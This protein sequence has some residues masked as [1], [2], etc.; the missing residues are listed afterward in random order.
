[1]SGPPP[2]HNLP[3]GSL[4]S[5]EEHGQMATAGA[6]SFTDPL[7]LVGRDSELERVNTRVRSTLSGNLNVVAI[8]GEPGIGKT[9]FARRIAEQLQAGQFVVVWARSLE[10]DWQPQYQ[11]W[12][13]ILS[14]AFAAISW[15]PSSEGDP[16]WV[17]PLLPIVARLGI[18]YP[19]VRPLG[20]LSTQE[21]Q[22]RVTDAI[23]RCL[24]EL[25]RHQPLLIVIDDLQWT[26]PASLRVL[27]HL[28]A[29]PESAS[30][31]VVATIRNDYIDRFP[32]LADL[33]NGLR[34]EDAFEEIGLQGLPEAQVGHLMWIVGHEEFPSDVVRLIAEGTQGNP[35]F[36]QEMIQHFLEGARHMPVEEIATAAGSG[37]LTIPDSLR[38]V[39]EHRVSRLTDRTQRMLRL[40]AVCTDGF[41]FPML[42]ALTSLDE[43]EL[44]DSIDEALAARL[45]APIEPG[46]ERYDFQHQLVRRA[47]YDTWSPSRRVRLHRALA[48]SLEHI[49]GAAA[50]TQAG[51]I[52]AHYHISARVPGAEA[53]VPFALMAAEQAERRF[54]PDQAA[55][56][57]RMARDMAAAL[58]VAERAA[59]SRSLAVAE[60]NALWLDAALVTIDEALHAMGEAGM[61][62]REQAQ[63]I[64]EAVT[65]LH[66]GGAAT[67]LW[68]PLLYRGLALVP[69]DDEITW[70]RLTLLI[71]RFEPVTAGVINGSRWLGS[72]QR[73]VEIARSSGDEDLFA[74]SLQPWDLWDRE[75]T[76]HLSELIATWHKPS[77]I[78]RALTVCGADWLYHHG[79][80]RRARRHFDNLLAISERQVS[81]PGQAE[82]VV[83]LGIIQTALGNLPE[84]HV[85]HDRA[86]SLVNRLG[87]GHRLHASL[88]WLR[89]FLTEFDEGDW[90]EVATFFAAYIADPRVG[91]TTIAFD[92]AALAA[93]ALARRARASMH[94]SCSAP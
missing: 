34:R 1:M 84:A 13:D 44:L 66:D 58:P 49:H 79:E 67:E 24:Q 39:V 25:A 60:A 16:E 54:A 11:I 93:L 21:E 78:I 94:T 31:M 14:Q 32:P 43:D 12:D 87:A 37:E 33:V 69:D 19:D 5:P 80:F 50:Y 77:A 36:V 63:F 53:G 74:R 40:A 4:G 86:T 75:W 10:D 83:R 45:I 61:G 6:V 20:D 8:T 73:A 3:N 90:N 7:P 46:P 71:E 81:I 28:G 52:A 92:D 70:A 85:L 2:T 59:I 35:F 62:A 26:D 47:L 22:F 76:E 88:W 89:A 91:R 82:A 9:R 55:A 65:A 18:A 48:T 57:L 38:Q 42:R 15:P 29:S 41:D 23:V 51:P 68:T 27:R 56:Y 17:A 64:A 72:D 30:L